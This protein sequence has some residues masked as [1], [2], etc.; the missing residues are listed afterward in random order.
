MSFKR[1][2]LQGA[3]QGQG[4]YLLRCLNPLSRGLQNLSATN[5][6]ELLGLFFFC[7]TLLCA[8]AL[9]LTEIQ[10]H[11]AACMQQDRIAPRQSK[12]L[13]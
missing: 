9:T 8:H 10:G 5:W 6:V 12:E 4:G 1:A 11:H 2:F 7:E 3:L 13:S